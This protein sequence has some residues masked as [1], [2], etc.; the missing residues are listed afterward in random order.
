[1]IK[2]LFPGIQRPT[3]G[4]ACAPSLARRVAKLAGGESVYEFQVQDIPLSGSSTRAPP[5][6]ENLLLVLGRGLGHHGY[7]LRRPPRDG[8]EADRLIQCVRV[9]GIHAGHGSSA[10]I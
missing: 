4:W 6:R 9:C 5:L 2:L 10:R 7:Y 3:R 1:M 8:F